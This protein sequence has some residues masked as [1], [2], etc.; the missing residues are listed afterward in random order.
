[1]GSVEIGTTIFVDRD[2]FVPMPSMKR[3]LRHA[4]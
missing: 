1:V 4:A 2:D 3:G